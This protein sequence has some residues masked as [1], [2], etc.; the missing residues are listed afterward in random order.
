MDSRI[1]WSDDALSD[2]RDVAEYIGRDRPS[3]AL[4]IGAALIDDV[5]RL[6]SFPES[7][8]R[9]PD[10]PNL[11]EIVHRQWRVFYRLEPDRT[12]TIL[13]IWHAARGE[14]PIS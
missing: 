8:R 7:G 12:V 6:A 11:R 4:R 5:E 3:T 14:P 1:V 10:D 13:R 9:V 2:L